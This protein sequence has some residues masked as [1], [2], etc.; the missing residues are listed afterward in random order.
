MGAGLRPADLTPEGL[1][2]TWLARRGPERTWLGVAVA[3]ATAMAVMDATLAGDARL[4]RFL[5]AAPLLAAVAA[6]PRLVAAV[7]AYATLLAVVLGA[8]HGVFGDTDQ[9]LR[10]GAVVLGGAIAVWLAT[11]RTR[12]RAAR[13]RYALLAETGR[14]AQSSLDPDVMLIEVARL[15][16]RELCDWCFAFVTGDGGRVRQVAAVHADVERQKV[17]WDLLARYPLDPGREEGPAVAMRELRP[18]LYPVVEDDVL[19][20]LSA[21]D[22]NLRLL[23]AL[24]M[25]SAMVVPLVE[26][27][28]ALGAL[29]FAT[30][31]SGATF[32]GADLALAEELAARVATALDNARLYTEL[33]GAERELRG[34]HDE[35]QAIL[36][37]V[38]DAITV[39]RPDGQ[40][41]Y[42][43]DAAVRSLGFGSMEELMTTPVAEIVGRF[44]FTDEN[45]RPVP[46]ESLPGRRALG[47]EAEPEPMLVRSRA[48][49]E[50]DDRWVRV[51]A[52]AVFGDD[53][54][55]T[56]AINVL[57]DVTDVQEA[58]ERQR[59]IARAGVILQSSL[60]YETT[61]T[62]VA[63]LAVPRLADWCAVDVLEDDG[64]IR[65]V[66]VAHT[67]PS[68][69]EIARELQRRYPVDPLS[70]TGV[71]NVMRTRESEVYPEISDEMLVQGAIDA[72][73]LAILRE[74]GMRSVMI[75]PMVARGRMLG[76][77]SF[78]SAE[79]RRTFGEEDLLLAQRLAGRC[80]LAIDNARLFRE[81]AHIA[82]TLQESLLPPE[83]PQPPGL[84]VAARFRAAG[85]G[86]D[87]GGDFY[88]VFDCREGR[89]AVVIGDVC[90]KGPEAAAVTALARYTVRASAMTLSEP[91]VILAT[92]NEAMLRQRDDRR[93]CTVLYCRSERTETGVRICFASGGHPLPIVVRADGEVIE[94]GEPGTLLGIVPDPDL[95]DETV[96]L[97]PG[98]TAI[99][100][101]DGVTDAAAPELFQDPLELA[102]AL[103]TGPERAAEDVAQELLEAAVGASGGEPRDDIAIIVLRVPAMTRGL[104]ETDNGLRAHA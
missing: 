60:D 90:G 103:E 1:R 41:V 47:G 12:A 46:L 43:N 71:P 28:R 72:E 31:D 76:A 16:A 15:V 97:G 101:T 52:T 30:E 98:D 36:D 45:G 65:H 11:S 80:A 22:E 104:V 61:L 62:N 14:I 95:S 24:R 73:H 99:L 40:L 48:V 38:A 81:R 86:F 92:L 19:R 35:L 77:L 7:G 33:R 10:V 21:D 91:S 82:R 39:Q 96:E 59:F 25:R 32:T 89:W 55:P 58:A 2:G 29:A 50:A 49:G 20:A 4:S 17:A 84:E 78:V 64:G 68:K 6:R 27:G 53:G 85:E 94:P 54:R 44:Q 75:V 42:A 26:H 83:L 3:F 88:D 23:R 69:V 13:R 79:S 18:L 102:R 56:A 87:V 100:Y 67:D 51:K 8:I 70:E 57:E 9:V 5:F 63:E 66:V 93:F 34:S 74:L 37:G